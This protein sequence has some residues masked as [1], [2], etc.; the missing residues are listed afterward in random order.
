MNE[1]LQHQNRVA[2][3]VNAEQVKQRE[4]QKLANTARDRMEENN[5]SIAENRL[6]TE[7]FGEFAVKFHD[8]IQTIH[9]EISVIDEEMRRYRVQEGEL[10]KLNVE[11]ANAEAE[12]NE[13]R[14][15]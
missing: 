6:R 11:L 1:K 5:R 7:G 14:N 3:L 13:V 9:G 2:Q 12:Y 8:S 4:L 10:V 15:E